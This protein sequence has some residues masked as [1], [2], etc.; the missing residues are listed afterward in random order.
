MYVHGTS[1]IY[2]YICILCTVFVHVFVF[3]L[4]HVIIVVKI[5]THTSMFNTKWTKK[6]NTNQTRKQENSWLYMDLCAQSE[7][8]KK[9]LFIQIY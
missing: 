7:S 1:T 3:V 5:V 4:V 9:Q 2:I 8:L 6:L